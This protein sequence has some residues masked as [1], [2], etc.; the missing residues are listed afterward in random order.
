MLIY[1]YELLA[2]KAL[3]I[4]RQDFWSMP[5]NEFLTLIGIFNKEY[6]QDN[7]TNGKMS[8]ED[9]KNLTKRMKER[10]AKAKGK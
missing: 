1:Q 3:K 5:V 8:M 7:E 9:Y 4:S 6:N 2:L 10:D